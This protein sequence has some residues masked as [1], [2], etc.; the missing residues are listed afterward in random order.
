MPHETRMRKTK[1]PSTSNELQSQFGGL[2]QNRVGKQALQLHNPL[3][4]AAPPRR[5]LQLHIPLAA[6]D[7]EGPDA[8]VKD[9]LAKTTLGS[10]AT[11]GCK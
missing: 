11:S 8:R 1:A 4:L 9:A 10:E 2:G 6:R 7:L 3:S 5:A